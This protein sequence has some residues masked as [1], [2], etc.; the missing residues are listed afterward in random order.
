MDT[1]AVISTALQQSA[2]SL[3]R[4][5]GSEAISMVNGIFSRDLLSQQSHTVQYG[6][7]VDENGEKIDEV[8]VTVFRA[9]KS[10]TKEDIV[11]ISCHGGPFVTRRVLAL[12]LSQGARL[13]LPGEFTQRAF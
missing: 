13:A 8:L 2:I 12:V 10:Y 9:P 5:S 7:I 4:V 6:Y 3:I 1:I 11:E